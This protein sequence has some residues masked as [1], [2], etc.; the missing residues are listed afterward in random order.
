VVSAANFPPPPTAVNIG[1]VDRSRTHREKV[2]NITSIFGEI[3]ARFPHMSAP[4][5]R[6]AYKNIGVL[7]NQA[8]PRSAIPKR[9]HFKFLLVK[10]WMGV[11]W[12][13]A[14]SNGFTKHT[15]M[16]TH[17]NCV[18]ETNKSGFDSRQRQYFSFSL[19]REAL[20]TS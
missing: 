3:F 20:E 11:S 1:S 4:I 13:G 12:S 19:F 8:L 14:F 17:H 6:R 9:P 7:H 10:S 15:K 18:L 5:H 16:L 2:R